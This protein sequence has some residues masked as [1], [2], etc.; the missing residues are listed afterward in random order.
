[1]GEVIRTRRDIRDLK[2]ECGRESE[3]EKDCKLMELDN[4]VWAFDAIQKLD[5]NDP[6][7]FFVIAGYH[8]Q[9]FR[10]AGYTNASWWGG[11]CNH[12]NILFPT[13]HRAYLLR[14]EKALQA[15]ARPGAVIAL[16]YWNE[17]EQ[18]SLVEGIPKIF[19]DKE[20]KFTTFSASDNKTIRN[21]LFSYKFQ[22]GITDRLKPNPGANYTKPIDYETVRFP[23]SGLVG[24]PHDTKDTL[25]HNK[26][27][28][29]LGEDETN[30]M[31][32]GNVTT[33]LNFSHFKN[34]DGALVEAGV[35]DKFN[36]CLKAPNYTVFSNTTSAQRW[37]DDH[38]SK[39]NPEPVVSLESP[40][41]SIH[42]AIG[43]F[44]VPGHRNYDR[45]AGANGDMGEN[46]TAAFDPIFFFHHCFIDLMFWKWQV[47]K[48]KTKS[49]DIIQGYPGTNSVDSQGPT[50]GVAGGTWLTLDSPLDPFKHSDLP[51]DRF[52]DPTKATTSNDVVNIEQLNY[53]YYPR[54][55]RP[56]MI[57][58]A[59]K[60]PFLTVSNIDRAKIAGSFVVSAWAGSGDGDKI[61]VGTEAVLSRWQVTGCQNCQNH[62]DV[63]VHIPMEGWS[64]NDAK[65]LNFEALVHTR[66]PRDDRDGGIPQP[67]ALN[68]IIKLGTHHLDHQASL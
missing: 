37:N 36:E 2:C 66:T 63:R 46:D 26:E 23:F 21:P 3:H 62:L 53:E 45:V 67:G 10:G 47:W 61:L 22:V 29:D 64:R 17:T 19:L 48:G 55:E 33:W 6:D 49:L 27:M 8:G 30:R 18:R 43:G 51:P 52:D 31:L 24:T 16:P 35:N 38:L 5:P 11:Y 28:H 7:S 59:Q 68:P 42:L 34:S 58:I 56:L 25:F 13:W 32:N 15:H 60:V 1:M 41:N 9:P 44:Q 54:P 12:G 39:K 50:P 4:L 40:H 20:Y 65:K 14:L 57:P